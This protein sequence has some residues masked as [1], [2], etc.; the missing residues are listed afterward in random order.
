MTDLWTCVV[1]MDS[2]NTSLYTEG[3]QFAACE[4]FQYEWTEQE[5]YDKGYRRPFATDYANRI[6]GTDANAFG[7][8]ITSSK[9]AVFISDIYRSC[10]LQYSQDEDWNGVTTRRFNIQPK[11][12]ENSTANPVNAQFYAFG[13]SGMENTTAA[14]GVPVFV[15]FPHFLHGDTRLVSAVEGLNPNDAEHES[16]LDMEP[17]TGLL[18]QA[19]KRLQV[20]YQMVNKKFPQTNPQDINLATS[21]CS[22]FSQIIEL[23]DQFGN[24]TI[25]VPNCT[26]TVFTELFTCFGTPMEWKFYND[27][28]FFPYGWADEHF[29]LPDSDA[30][31]VHDSLFLIQD[32]AHQTQFWALIAAGILFTIILAMLYRGHL[33]MLARGETV[34]HAFDETS[35]SGEYKYQPVKQGDGSGKL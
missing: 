9:L 28:I 7:R 12:L 35:P 11:D 29:K 1:P 13:P 19:H 15:S 23:V 34:W 14:T 17:Q 6:W 25:P 26:L 21:L 31:D 5:A 24:M 30:D 8:P 32:L 4:L 33:D 2:Q 16:N 18:T 27:E 3:E 10:Y 22:N 20:N